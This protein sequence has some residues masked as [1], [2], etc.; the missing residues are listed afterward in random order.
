M[1]SSLTTGPRP[2]SP[3]AEPRKP[4]RLVRAA[5]GGV[6]GFALAFAAGQIGLIDW[7]AEMPG[8]DIAST[9]VAALLVMLGLFSMVAASS[10]ALYR[11][12]AENYREGDPLDGKVLRYLRVSGL[13]LLLAAALL[14]APPLAVRFGLT[15]DAAIPVAI[16]IAVLLALQTWL[17]LCILRSSDELSRAA[18]TEASVASFWLLQLGLFGWA[19]LAKL[20]LAASV[21]LWTLM[22]ISMV[23]Y[24]VV[25][26]VAAIRRG[27][28]A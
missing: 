14:L 17:N 19:V 12:M 28:F 21:S 10:S 11:R 20:G 26:I 7:V 1:P 13:V 18:M 6:V 25:S 22:T 8:E 16:G 9:A 15:G 5:I 23:I 27:M 4:R 24:L 2:N 3:M